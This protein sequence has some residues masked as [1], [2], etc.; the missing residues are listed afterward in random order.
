I[1]GGMGRD[2]DSGNLIQL[3]VL[4]IVA[5]IAAMIIQLAISRSREYLAD[6]RGA[7]VI[8]DP[9]ALAS[10]LE[11]IHSGASINPL[12]FGNPSTSSLFIINPFRGS[13]LLNLLSTHPPVEKRLER[14][15]ALK[16]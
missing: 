8:K 12:R 7:T 11:K 1:F 3:L 9:E 2:R 5:P 13:G 15:R 4:A 10:A 16:I 6:E 14:L